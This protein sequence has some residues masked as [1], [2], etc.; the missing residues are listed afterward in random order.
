MADLGSGED[1]SLAGDAVRKMMAELQADVRAIAHKRLAAERPGHILQ[2][3]ALAHEAF[4]RLLDQKNLAR[5]SPAEFLAA[6]A[7][8][9][10]RVLIDHARTEL[11][12]KRAAKRVPLNGVEPVIDD[13]N[14]RLLV[15][16]D[17]LKK[18]RE[19]SRREYQV[20]MLRFFSGMTEGETAEALRIPR[21]T[22]SRDWSHAR[23]WLKSQ[24][25]K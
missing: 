5:C 21:R 20:V 11:A 18:L 22:V 4:L 10:R 13:P 8:T 7:L 19:H 14:L 15:L 17:L 9:I 24:M 12:L 25:S 3:T 16:D 23:A 6:A 1:M 2:T